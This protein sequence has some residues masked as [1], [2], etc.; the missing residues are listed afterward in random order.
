MDTPLDR[1]ARPSVRESVLAMVTTEAQEPRSRGSWVIWGAVAV[2][3]AVR[4]PLLGLPAWADEAGFLMVGGGWHLGDSPGDQYLYDTYWVDRPPL[5][6]TV[7]G[8]AERLGGLVALRILGAI[9]AAVT[10][11]CVAWIANSVA[12]PRA[13]RWAAV[14]GAALLSTPFHWSFMVDGELVAAPFVALGI[15]C[16]IS[17]FKTDGRRGLLLCCAGGAAAAAAMLTKQNFADVVVFM[18]AL[19]FMGTL[20]RSLELWKTVRLS[21]AFLAGAV[22][23]GAV[24]AAWTVA[25]GTSLGSVYYAMYAFRL[26]AADAKGTEAISW[27]RLTSMGTAAVLSGLALLA[28][29]VAIS[30]VRRRNRDAYVLALLTVV[31]FDIFSVAAGT[32]YWLHYLIQPAVP[33]A[34]LTGIVVARGS[35]ARFLSVLAVATALVAWAVLVMSPPQTA[36]ELVGE[37]VGAASYADDSIVTLPGRSNVSYA[38]GLPSPYPYL[39]ALPKRTLDP[40]GAELKNLLAGP[41]APT[42]LVTHRP[43]NPQPR[44]GSVAARIADRYRAVARICGRV[45]YVDKD[46]ERDQPEANPRPDATRASQCKSVTVLPQV[47]REFS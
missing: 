13:A 25:H 42:W 18:V 37:A 22:G 28:I 24:V 9:A 43:V 40:G 35:L 7:Y 6:I 27:S 8:L 41:R 39:W 2:T 19:V 11:V 34:A 20:L 1:M 16:V 14:T 29:W 31:A 17:G 10:V 26:D 47:L 45:V 12:G 44:P 5:L 4:L 46:V 21:G 38:A 32:N 15:G 23:F 3:V 36:E 30:G 33:V